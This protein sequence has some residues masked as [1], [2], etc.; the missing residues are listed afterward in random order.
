MT[1][2]NNR[3]RSTRVE[4]TPTEPVTTEVTLGTPTST[5]AEQFDGNPVTT[6]VSYL[7]EPV[8]VRSPTSGPV[9]VTVGWLA[10]A[11]TKVIES[12]ER[13]GPEPARTQA[14]TETSRNRGRTGNR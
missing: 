6:T 7:N 14:H 10:D 4:P 5:G 2:R 3:V 11:E 8:V 13:P 12:A 9:I 1:L